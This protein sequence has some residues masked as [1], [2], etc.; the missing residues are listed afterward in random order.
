MELV[1]PD[2]VKNYFYDKLLKNQFEKFLAINRDQLS[3]KSFSPILINS[4]NSYLSR[5]LIDK[6]F[7]HLFNDEKIISSNYEHKLNSVKNFSFNVKISKNH[8]E[9]SPSE[10]GI[11][12]RN[13]V[14]EYI[15]EAS[16]MS[17]IVTGNK[18]NIIVWNVD[19]IGEIAFESLHNIIKN[20]EDTANFICISQSINKIDN[21]IFSSVVL[22]NIPSPDKNFYVNFF[23]Y[24]KD[25]FKMDDTHS[26]L[27]NI[28]TGCTNYN[29]NSFL[30]NIAIFY[31]FNLNNL[32]GLENS[33]RKFIEAL[34]IKVTSKNKITDTFVEEIRNSLYELY[35]YHFKFDEIINLF[36]EFAINDSNITEA[37]KKKIVE[38][39]CYFNST[40]SRGNKEIIHLEAFIFNFMNVYFFTV[41]L[42]ILKKPRKIKA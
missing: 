31:N 21:A 17:N 11:N 3:K 12:D 1:L 36:L 41:E 22:L 33:F 34:Y 32:E 35:V 9:V 20:N 15:N 42:P 25:D 30:K 10:Y 7:N 2:K 26:D 40:S 16:S 5:F 29:F 13:I 4:S 38:L 8:I 14:S 27:K 37:K 28:K 23:N 19:K 6:I 18:K 39:A 24:F